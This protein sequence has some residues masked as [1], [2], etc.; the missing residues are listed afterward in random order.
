MSSGTE[1]LI[2]RVSRLGKQIATMDMSY[3]GQ[4]QG[5]VRSPKVITN[6]LFN[7]VRVAHDLWV[8]LFIE[9]NS[10]TK[11]CF[12]SI[13]GHGQ[14]DTS[15]IGQ[16]LELVFHSKIGIHLFQCFILSSLG[17]SFFLGG[18]TIWDQKS[19]DRRKFGMFIA[20]SSFYNI[21]SGFLICEKMDL[22]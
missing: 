21:Y 17:F 15:K 5:Q 2:K 6:Y 7:G 13:S 11:K 4:V 9:C 14:V 3:Q 19:W 8:T 16:N 20:M 22:C 12:G 10:E 18:G 1:E